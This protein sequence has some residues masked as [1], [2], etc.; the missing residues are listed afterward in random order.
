MKKLISLLLIVSLIPGIMCGCGKEKE[1]EESIEFPEDELLSEYRNAADLPMETVQD[2][3]RAVAVYFY[4]GETK[5]YGE[6]YIPEGEGPFPV[7]IIAG[8]FA[9][10]HYG[11]QGMAQMFA[12]SGIVG[13]VF[14]P[15]DTGYMGAMI[16]DYLNWSPLKEAADIES[17]V[18]AMSKLS[19]V[20]DSNI[21]LWGHS[22]GGFASGYVGFKNPGLIKGMV[23]VEPAFYLNEEAKEQFPD[24]DD[25]PE[26]VEGDIYFG[27][28]YFEDLCSFD[29]Y[30]LMA[31]YDRNVAVYA[32]TESPSV[33][34]DMPEL[35]TRAEELLPSCKIT[36]VNT[37][38]F[39]NGMPMT[40]VIMGTVSFVKNNMSE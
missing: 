9:T 35:L 39:F 8:G 36:Y 26:I 4:R 3:G 38:H 24:T 2:A 19:Y 20:D 6:I 27:R 21:F 11:Y 17:I 10:S 23:L 30:D 15:S 7:V 5:F 16:D 31:A 18:S 1:I 33:G 25:I 37:D 14:D 32:G 12:E 13:V 28:I 34:A 40:R 22:M 29:I